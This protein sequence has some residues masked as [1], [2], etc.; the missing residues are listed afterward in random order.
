[1]PFNLKVLGISGDRV[2]FG[3]DAEYRGQHIHFDQATYSMG[4]GETLTMKLNAQIQGFGGVP[5]QETELEARPDG[6]YH[7]SPEPPP[8][9]PLL[10]KVETEK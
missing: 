6:G 3:I 7:F 2:T 4:P 8:E 9:I 10:Y 1:M 5:D